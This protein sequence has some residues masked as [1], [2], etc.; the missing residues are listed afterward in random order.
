MGLPMRRAS[1][2]HSEMTIS[3]S[4]S[5]ASGGSPSALQP[6]SSGAEAIQASSA[7]DHSRVLLYLLLM[8]IF[9]QIRKRKKV[10]F[11][12]LVKKAGDA[13]FFLGGET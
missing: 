12:D 4:A 1:S 11:P 8:W 6:G 9:Y 10:L 5:A 3:S 7:S 13:R 2:S